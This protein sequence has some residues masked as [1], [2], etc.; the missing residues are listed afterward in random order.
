ML[1]IIS[2]GKSVALIEL[3]KVLAELFWRYDF[4]LMNALKP[5]ESRCYGIHLQKEFWVTV[6]RRESVP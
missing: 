2:L 6:R 4:H 1:T 3:N 5:W